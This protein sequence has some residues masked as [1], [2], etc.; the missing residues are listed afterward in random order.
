MLLTHTSYYFIQFCR[1]SASFV[2]AALQTFFKGM[3]ILASTS[4]PRSREVC[5]ISLQKVH[6]SGASSETIGDGDGTT[7]NGVFITC[8]PGHSATTNVRN[9]DGKFKVIDSFIPQ[10]PVTFPNAK[11]PQGFGRGGTKP[12]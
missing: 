12:E 4:K 9:T 3:Y 5:V 11:V 2:E 8:I 7:A 10:T 1:R 6:D